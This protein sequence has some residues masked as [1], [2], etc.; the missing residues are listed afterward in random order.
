MNKVDV[1]KS[2]DEVRENI[3]RLDRQ[4]VAL[5]AARGGYVKQAARFK[6]TTDEV[7]APQRVEQVITRVLVLSAEMGALP[8]VTEAVY[9]AMI[10]AF[11]D[12]ELTEHA[13]LADAG[14]QP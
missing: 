9:R 11:I 14:D 8:S 3:D 12:A 13:V 6:R 7:R 10:S 1:C 2:L 5:L 4:I